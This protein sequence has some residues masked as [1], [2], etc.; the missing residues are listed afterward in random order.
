MGQLVGRRASDDGCQRARAAGARAGPSLAGADQQRRGGIRLC[1]DL[2]GNAALRR[3]DGHYRAADRPWLYLC[4]AAAVLDRSRRYGVANRLSERRP[5]AVR[6]RDRHPCGPHRPAGKPADRVDH[7]G[8][9]RDHGDD[10]PR[11]GGLRG[12]RA[13]GDDADRDAWRTGGMD[14]RGGRRVHDVPW[15]RAAD[16]GR[17]ARA[18]TGWRPLPSA[19]G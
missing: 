7:G 1:R 11:P 4:A 17:G 12:R 18:N 10:V 14:G 6:H 2:Y 3:S 5:I 15:L 8:H 16:D 13:S 9:V 19:T